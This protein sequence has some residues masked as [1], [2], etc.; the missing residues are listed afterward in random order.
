MSFAP[1]QLFEYPDR[2][3]DS[4]SS[5]HAPSFDASSSSHTY[6]DY[7]ELS[8]DSSTYTDKLDMPMYANPDTVFEKDIPDLTTHM[9]LGLRRHSPVISLEML[10][11]QGVFIVIVL[12]YAIALGSIGIAI[13][14]RH[15]NVDVKLSLFGLIPLLGVLYLSTIGYFL[16]ECLCRCCF[17]TKTAIREQAWIVLTMIVSLVCALVVVWD[18]INDDDSSEMLVTSTAAL[19]AC[20]KL[21]WLLLMDSFGQVSVST[22]ILLLETVILSRK[23]GCFGNL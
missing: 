21:L 17:C 13:L 1:R 19:D 6:D 9:K 7:G 18:E 15:S 20:I 14:L 22:T 11:S 10:S 23:P 8:K 5:S 3:P 16:Y 4:V 2:A 12:T